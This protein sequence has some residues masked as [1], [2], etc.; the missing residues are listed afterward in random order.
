MSRHEYRTEYRGRPVCVVA[1][2]DRPLQGCYMFIEY[3]DPATGSM[4]YSNLDD[5]DS[6]PASF[7]KFLK[8]YVFLSI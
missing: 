3:L 1:G 6:H 4:P 2:W 8:I 5:E 7:E